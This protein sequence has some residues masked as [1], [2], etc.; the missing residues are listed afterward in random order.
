[1]F[2][3]NIF[4]F[5][6]SKLYILLHQSTIQINKAKEMKKVI[7]VR[8]ELENKTHGSMPMANKSKSERLLERRDF[9]PGGEYMGNCNTGVYHVMGCHDINA[10]LDEHKIETDNEEGIYRP[11][12]HCKPGIAKFRKFDSFKSSKDQ[13]GDVELCYD[14]RIERIFVG[15][16]CDCGSSDGILKMRPHDGGVRLLNR[17]GKW[18]VWRECYS[19]GHQ[20]SLVHAIQKRKAMKKFG[21]E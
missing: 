7:G 10:M 17:Q 16:K 2:A 12:G 3:C 18:W 1:M 15:I 14:P 4:C 9:V 8:S 19:C 11:C 20:L 13:P 21:D 5:K 6:K